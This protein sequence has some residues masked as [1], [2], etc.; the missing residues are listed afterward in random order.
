MTVWGPGG[1][2]TCQTQAQYMTPPPFSP[3]T[4]VYTPT[5][6]SVPPVAYVPPAAPYVALAQ[7]PYT[8]SGFGFAGDLAAWFAIVVTALGGAYVLVRFKGEDMLSALDEVAPG[9]AR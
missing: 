1:T 2:A 9:L 3:L 6:P 5:Y 4:P 7:I 8:G